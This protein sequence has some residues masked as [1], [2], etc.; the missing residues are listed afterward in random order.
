MIDQFR[1]SIGQVRPGSAGQAAGFQATQQMGF[2][3]VQVARGRGEERLL[4]EGSRTRIGQ[5]SE[6]AMPYLEHEGHRLFYREQG[7]GPL[8]LILPGNT[9]SS[10]HHL[11][12]LACFGR[13]FHAIALDFRGTGLSE[14][15]APWPDDW[16]E[17]AAHDVAAL[18]KRTGEGP[19][20]VM[21]TSGGGMVALLLAILHPE[22]VRGVIA[23][24]CIEV[25]PP[26]LLRQEM[27]RRNPQGPEAAAFWRSGHGADWEEVVAADSAMMRRFAAQGG[28]LFRGQLG[29]IGCPV[30]FTVSLADEMLPDPGAQVCHMVQQI[31]SSRAVIFPEG[32]H[33]LMWS[34]AGDFRQVAGQWLAAMQGSG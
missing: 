6:D 28:D 32:T 8:L 19:A 25:Y 15:L 9:A 33:P 23:D 14:R 13:S 3:P 5:K 12:E 26:E 27:A 11:G 7:H 10:A 29:R 24:S 20:Y 31:P 17:Q 30:L 22:A 4:S 18:V 2:P 16:Y 1:L 34:R 21:G